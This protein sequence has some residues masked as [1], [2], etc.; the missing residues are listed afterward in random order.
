M[1]IELEL[2]VSE[3]STR[4]T[5]FH[6]PTVSKDKFCET[7]IKNWLPTGIELGSFCMVTRRHNYLPTFN[8]SWGSSRTPCDNTRK[9]WT[10]LSLIPLINIKP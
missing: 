2:R 3:S 6:A 1:V 8:D 5:K 10:H 9:S 4:T 7:G